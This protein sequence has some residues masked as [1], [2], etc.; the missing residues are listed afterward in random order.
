MA[1]LLH[2]QIATKSNCQVVGVNLKT[3]YNVENSVAVGKG[4]DRIPGVM[5]P[6]KSRLKEFFDALQAH[7]ELDS[8]L[9]MRK[10]T[11]LYIS[12]TLDAAVLI[13]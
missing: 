12:H 8:T 11:H 4:S 5:Q 2:A 9:S 3:E 1:N 13:T 6:T 10:M 7:V